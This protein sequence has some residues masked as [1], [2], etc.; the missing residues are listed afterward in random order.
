MKKPSMELDKKNPGVEINKPPY[1]GFWQRPDV[2]LALYV[3]LF[4]LLWFWWQSDLG[5]AREQIPYS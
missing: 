1:P 5:V 3:L 4:S 2:R